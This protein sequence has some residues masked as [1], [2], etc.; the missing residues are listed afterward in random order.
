MPFKKRF[1]LFQDNAKQNLLRTENIWCMVM[2]LKFYKCMPLLSFFSFLYFSFWCPPK[3]E[4]L[5]QLPPEPHLVW[6]FGTHQLPLKSYRLIQP[7]RTPFSAWKPHHHHESHQPLRSN[8]LKQVLSGRISPWVPKAYGSCRAVLV[9]TALQT[10][11]RI[12][13][14]CL[15]TG[16]LGWRFLSLGLG[17]RRCTPVTVTAVTLLSLPGKVNAMALER[18]A[19][20]LVKPR[21]QEEQWRFHPGCRTLYKLFKLLNI[22]GGRWEF[23]QWVYVFFADLEKAFSCIPWSALWGP[24][25]P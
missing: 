4:L 16:R 8:S 20:L 1:F 25:G 23:A 17:T 10:S 22:F 15:Y 2:K 19:C 13:G 6:P 12:L 7:D 24:S 14:W 21:I 11:H 5:L 3:P 18:R 9:D